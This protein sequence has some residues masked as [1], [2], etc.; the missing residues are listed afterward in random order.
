MTNSN[1]FFVELNTNIDSHE[2]K[3]PNGK[4]VVFNNSHNTIFSKLYS[5]FAGGFFDTF[6][7][8]HYLAKSEISHFDKFIVVF[9][10][11]V[12]TEIPIAYGY[13]YIPTLNSNF[14]RVTSG[15][16]WVDN[17]YRRQGIAH[18]LADI[19]RIKSK[20]GAIHNSCMWQRID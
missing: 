16:I 20:S 11:N 1:L 3:L 10:S 8:Q 17:A 13:T 9:D 6:H 18:K 15:G 2:I 12:D 7:P 19:L 14:I 5:G 4:S